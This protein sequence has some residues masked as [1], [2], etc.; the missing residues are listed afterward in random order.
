MNLTEFL[1]LHVKP[2]TGCTEI[3]ALALLSSIS[4]NAISKKLPLFLNKNG[5]ES[6]QIIETID[7]NN[8]KKI[9]IQ[10]DKQLYKNALAVTIPSKLKIKGIT[11]V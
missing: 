1:K 10:V 7:H 8:I 3:A 11:C 5:T 6:S 2:A 9:S 4:F